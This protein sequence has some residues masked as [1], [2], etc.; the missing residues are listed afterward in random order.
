MPKLLDY[1]KEK[2]LSHEDVIELIRKEFDK[3]ESSEEEVE[4]VIEEEGEDDKPEEVEQ[5]EEA[6][7]EQISDQEEV[8]D[9]KVPDIKKEVQKE[10]KKQLKVIR[11]TPSK[12]IISDKPVVDRTIK[13]NWYEEIV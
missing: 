2:G 1:I 5:E 6:E 11:K 4:E 12:G 13:K 3:P 7:I 9:T 10:I 8:E